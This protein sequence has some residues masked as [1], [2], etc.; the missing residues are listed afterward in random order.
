MTDLQ[1]DLMPTVEKLQIIE[2]ELRAVRSLIDGAAYKLPD[3]ARAAVVG[4]ADEAT[5]VLKRVFK[6]QDAI[7][8]A[9]LK[10]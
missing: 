8:E 10:K 4:V 7:R 5:L 2:N 9:A 6:M 3:G 1:K